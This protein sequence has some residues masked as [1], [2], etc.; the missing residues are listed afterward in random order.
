MA[1]MQLVGL[2]TDKSGRDDA[3]TPSAV[4]RSQNID[5]AFVSESGTFRRINHPTDEE[6]REMISLSP[7]ERFPFIK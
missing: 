1:K 3:Y 2:R 5:W 6:I 4:S 7:E